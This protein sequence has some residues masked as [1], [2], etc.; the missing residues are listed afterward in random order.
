M[1][2]VTFEMVK[3]DLCI[4]ARW[5]FTVIVMHQSFVT[6]GPSVPGNS[7]DIDFSLQSPDLCPAKLCQ[8]PCSIPGI[9]R[10]VLAWYQNTPAV[11]RHCRDTA[12]IKTQQLGFP[13]TGA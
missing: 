10:P 13:M 4:M 5:I 3:P 8:K 9:S 12:D 7:R 1:K 2:Q 11:P 6:K